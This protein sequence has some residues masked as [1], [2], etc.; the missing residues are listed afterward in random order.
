LDFIRE[1]LRHPSIAVNAV[2]QRGETPLFNAQSQGPGALSL[3]LSCP[4]VDV[5]FRNPAGLCV[6]VLACVGGQAEQV[7]E[8]IRH[9]RLDLSVI[10]SA[11]YAARFTR[12]PE[13]IEVICG[14]RA[15]RA[16]RRRAAAESD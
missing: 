13:I 8:L 15:L 4:V 2:D 9:P 3:L 1:L 11:I 16:R 5:N 6:L 10:P 14:D 12:H 7:R